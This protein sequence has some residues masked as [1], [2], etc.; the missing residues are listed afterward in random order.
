MESN[1]GRCGPLCQHPACWE[2]DRTRGPSNKRTKINSYLQEL[3][4]L[5]ST[6][7]VAIPNVETC[8]ALY[9]E[10]LFNLRKI[11]IWYAGS[12]VLTVQNLVVEAQGHVGDNRLSTQTSTPHPSLPPHPPQLHR[13]E[14]LLQSANSS[15]S[16]SLS[17]SPVLIWRPGRFPVNCTTTTSVDILLGKR[18]RNRSVAMKTHNLTDALPP[19]MSDRASRIKVQFS[20]DIF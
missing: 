4:R 14:V 11:F 6:A 13:V 1:N 10:R 20:N 3:L 9:L 17:F 19:G 2:A 5:R 12:S 18:A 16:S 15:P 7:E 8:G